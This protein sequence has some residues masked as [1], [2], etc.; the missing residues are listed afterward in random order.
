LRT[1]LMI[2]SLSKA[3]MVLSLKRRKRKEEISSRR[4]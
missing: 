4:N 1:F 3:S 2:I